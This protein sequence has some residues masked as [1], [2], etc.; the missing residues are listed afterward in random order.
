V[1]LTPADV[2]GRWVFS[3]VQGDARVFGLRAAARPSRAP[4]EAFDLDADGTFRRFS[5][6][7]GDA[8]AASYGRWTL[9]PSGRLLVTF[10]DGRP[11]LAFEIVAAGPGAL[12]VRSSSW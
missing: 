1:P 7:P 6:G 9:A 3:H 10:D 4:R 8:P 5:P 11:P 2:V 12:V